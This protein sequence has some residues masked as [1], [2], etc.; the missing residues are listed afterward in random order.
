V[1]R[2]IAVLGAEAGLVALTEGADLVIAG[3]RGYTPEV[4]AAW[5]HFPLAAS[6]P[7]SDAVRE[8]TPRGGRP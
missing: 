3:V 2:G 1:D 6:L 7:L 8:K 4:T 5:G